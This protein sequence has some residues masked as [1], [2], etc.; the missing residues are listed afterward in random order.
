METILSEQGSSILP[1]TR[2]YVGGHKFCNKCLSQKFSD[3]TPALRKASCGLSSITSFRLAERDDRR[4]RPGDWQPRDVLTRATTAPW[5]STPATA[6]AA[7]SAECSTPLPVA[8][9]EPPCELVP[10][11]AAP[12]WSA[13]PGSG[14]ATRPTALGHLAPFPVR[15]VQQCD[16]R[17]VD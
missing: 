12:K 9:W 11:P 13:P 4:F 10:G 2:H 15:S 3:S 8:G 14:D 16:E 6:S 7:R 5:H 1:T 17:C